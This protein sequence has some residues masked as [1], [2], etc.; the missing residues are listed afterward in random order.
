MNNPR[1]AI[2]VYV[3]NGGF[4]SIVAVP[5]AKLMLDKFFYGEIPESDLW[6]ETQML[7][8]STLPGSFNYLPGNTAEEEE[9]EDAAGE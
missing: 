6:L 7:N 2:C 4:G 3:Q 1:V 9:V 8:V 5:L